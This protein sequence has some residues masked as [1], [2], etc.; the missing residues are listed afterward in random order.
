MT[1]STT[2]KT[3]NNINDCPWCKGPCDLQPYLHNWTTKKPYAVK[4][5]LHVKC[6]QCGAAGP[7]SIRAD[8]AVEMWNQAFP[9]EGVEVPFN[10]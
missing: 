3:P 4:N 5:L 9:V 10:L 2:K 6:P 8:R 7:V 1:N